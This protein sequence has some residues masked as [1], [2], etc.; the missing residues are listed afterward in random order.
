MSI[1]FKNMSHLPLPRYLSPVCR[2]KK[3]AVRNN[4]F[5]RQFHFSKLYLLLSNPMVKVYTY[6][7]ADAAS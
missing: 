5:L 1:E 2:N 3:I 7:V 6:K 4:I